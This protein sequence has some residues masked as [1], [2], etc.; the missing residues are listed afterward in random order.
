M[1]RAHTSAHLACLALLCSSIAIC[2]AQTPPPFQPDPTVQ[3][4]QS[5]PQVDTASPVVA[6]ATFDPPVVRPGGTSTYRVTFNAMM[7]SVQW[8]EDLVAPKQLELQPGG[9]GQLLLPAG[10]SLQP[11]TTFNTRVKATN[12]GAFTIPRY[13]VYVYGKPVTVPAADLQ[14][15]EDPAV[16]VPATPEVRLSLG[17]TNVFVGQ[18]VSARVVLEGNVNGVV[19]ALAQIKLVGEGFVTDTTFARQTIQPMDAASGSL[20]AFVYETSLTPVT[21]G[22]LPI[23]AQGFTAGNQ[24]VGPIT[25][26]GRATI[27]GGTPLYE[28]RDTLPVML[29]VRTI[30]QDGRL[31][32]YHGGIGQF[33]VDSPA[34]STNSVQVGEPVTF[35]VNVMGSGNLARLIPPAPPKVEGWKVYAGKPDPGPAQLI[36]ARGFITFRFTLVPTSE[37]TKATP[38][39]PFSYFDPASE[40]YVALD[41]P[42]L[43]IAV[44]P[45]AVPINL[46]DFADAAA[47]AVG[48]RA[49]PKLSALA[50]GRGKT[51]ASLQPWQ[52]HPWFPLVQLAPVVLFAGLWGWDRRRRFLAANPEIVLR[53]RA[54]RAL[55]REWTAVRRAASVGDTPR[56]AAG[57]VSAFRVACA[58]HYPA[59]PRALVS[60]DVLPLLPESESAMHAAVRAVFAATNAERFAASQTPPADLLALRQELER[61]RTLLEEKL[62]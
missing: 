43:P 4:L 51:M 46:D 50:P 25:I 42:S 48:A 39:I 41:L 3:L 7:D 11:R 27:L 1:R 16:A 40:R 45:S 22:V 53:R 59:E 52:Q 23:T 54:R 61:A 30:P 34:L 36:E 18:P 56:F 60:T 26:T 2:L 31:P 20:P 58:P 10:A 8:P 35:S 24:F 62:R 57:V 37:K 33:R 9:R 21:A 19:Q 38:A 14:V 55:Q 5:Q 28:L 32:G 13:L 15:V 47:P 49:E 6:A 17:A 44:K 12:T 29:K